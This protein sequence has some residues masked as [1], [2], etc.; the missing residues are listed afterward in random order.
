MKQWHLYDLSNL[1]NLLFA[2]S[3]ISIGHIWLL[4]NLHHRDSWI[5]LWRQWQLN[6]KLGANL[7]GSLRTNSHTLF[8]I[9]WCQLL[10]ETDHVFAHV[11]QMN[12]ILGII[13]SLIQ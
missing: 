7:T 3:Q 2:A 4:F 12:D 8:N 10:I 9:S 5:N 1:I 11:L 6:L 13:R